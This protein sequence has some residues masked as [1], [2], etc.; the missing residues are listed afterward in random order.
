M[1][2]YH[3][4]FEL[5][6]IVAIG[7][8]IARLL[9]KL[10]IIKEFLKNDSKEGVN[11]TKKPYPIDDTNNLEISENIISQPNQIK[12][13]NECQSY[14]LNNHPLDMTSPPIS[15]ETDKPSHTKRILRRPSTKCK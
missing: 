14:P 8:V 13:F 15:Q 10:P 3:A 6:G 1:F 2:N 5:V 4:L 9:L 12:H 11:R 7:Y